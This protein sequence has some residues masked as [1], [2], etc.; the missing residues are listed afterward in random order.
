MTNVLSRRA[1]ALIAMFLFILSSSSCYNQISEELVAS[2]IPILISSNI[3]PPVTRV[4]DGEFESGDAMGFF[5]VPNCLSYQ[6]AFLSNCKF[7]YRA[8]RDFMPLSTVYYP[9]TEDLSSI[10]CYYPYHKDAFVED[11]AKLQVKIPSK[12]NSQ[13]VISNSEFLIAHKKDVYADTK[14]Q[15]LSFKHQLAKVE[16]Q[17]KPATGYSSEE[18]LRIDPQISIYGMPTRAYF[19]PST[20][21]Y[22]D[23]SNV[24]LIT[25][26]TNWRVDGELLVGTEFLSIPQKLLT[27]ATI[28]IIAENITYTCSFPEDF[29]L[30]PGTL[31]KLVIKY[32]PSK[33]IEIVNSESTIEVWNEGK[34]G[35]T[36]AM[37]LLKALSASKF[38]F[39]DTNIVQLVNGEG[40]VRAEVCL[41]L[42]KN[43]EINTQAVVVY[44]MEKDGSRSLRGLCIKT[45]EEG[46]YLDGSFVVWDK[47]TNAFQIEELTSGYKNYFFFSTE[48]ELLFEETASVEQLHLEKQYLNHQGIRYPMA[49]IGCD[50]WLTDNLKA[51]KKI[52][53]SPLAYE[54]GKVLINAGYTTV[55]DAPNDFLYSR[56]AI[57]SRQLVP[58]GWSLATEQHWLRLLAYVGKDF[59]L[60][61]AGSLWGNSVANNKTYFN[62]LRSGC[63]NRGQYFDVVSAFWIFD[64]NSFKLILVN[65]DLERVYNIK[66]I[67]SNDA[68]AS[69]RCVRI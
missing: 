6:D 43:E 28:Q 48:G 45:V 17:L 42:L 50:V 27:E 21:A 68:M 55:K 53:E 39:D 2:D 10:F 11:I 64:S 34:L 19:D 56:A 24:A 44:P 35:E 32:T 22:S 66:D 14:P 59:G 38:N 3:K 33:G 23:L 54:Q 15:K 47:L 29:S 69:V 12:Q 8:G 31:N 58:S 30:E 13:G 36:E 7:E 20:L 9:K 37:P 40:I 57:E 26:L 60:L 46:L 61:K 25:P 5:L 41:E 4:V 63:Y 51:S 52:D 49:K 1:M 67:T 16:L 18:I 65:D 62:M